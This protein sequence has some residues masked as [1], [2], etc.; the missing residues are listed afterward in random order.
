MGVTNLIIPSA[1]VCWQ[2][3]ST[4]WGRTSRECSWVNVFTTCA[5]PLVERI[6]ELVCQVWWAEQAST[7]Q[8]WASVPPPL[9]KTTSSLSLERASSDLFALQSSLISAAVWI[10]WK[11]KRVHCRFARF[12]VCRFVHLSSNLPLQFREFGFSLWVQHSPANYT[13]GRLD[14]LD[15]L[16]LWIL[17]AAMLFLKIDFCTWR[18]CAVWWWLGFQPPSLLKLLIG[19][20]D[21]TST[22]NLLVFLSVVAHWSQSPAHL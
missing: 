4:R 7:L 16:Q 9:C 11:A 18:K 1:V 8:L 13:F 19:A 5:A 20:S 10:D 22:H 3:L 17:F 12:A 15:K 6:F 21:W 2:S 14:K